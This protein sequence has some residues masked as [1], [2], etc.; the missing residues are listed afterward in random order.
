MDVLEA[1]KIEAI[2]YNMKIVTLKLIT[3]N[4]NI[5]ICYSITDQI[6]VEWW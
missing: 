5:V 4:K 2:F 1:G 6:T 3:E